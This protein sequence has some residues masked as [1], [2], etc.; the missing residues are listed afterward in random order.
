MHPLQRIFGAGPLGVVLSLTSLSAAWGLTQIADLPAI[1]GNVDIG[2]GVLIGSVLITAA[3][4]VWSFKSLPVDSRGREL[5]TAGA[6]RYV[7]HPLYSSFLL[8]FD[9]G[10]A[11]YLDNWI[12][13]LWAVGQFPLWGVCVAG[14][15]RLMRDVFGDAGIHTRSAVGMAELPFDIAVEIE[16]IFQ[17]TAVP[18][19]PR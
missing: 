9:F 16:G 8:S 4:V 15:E 1:H 7:R 6:F 19:L 18:A 2:M 3:G 5:I 12:Y 14:E 11:L 13:L 10:L 17:V